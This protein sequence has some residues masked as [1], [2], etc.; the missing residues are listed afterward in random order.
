MDFA[1]QDIRRP[2]SRCRHPERGGIGLSRSARFEAD[3]YSSAGKVIDE[4]LNLRRR[5]SQT[6]CLHSGDAAIQGKDVQ[7]SAGKALL[8][9]AEG[10]IAI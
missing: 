1:I 10:R 8:M 7:V 3:D 2:R 5:A 9:L 6:S 4:P